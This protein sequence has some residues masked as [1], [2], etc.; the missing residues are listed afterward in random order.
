MPSP[1]AYAFVA[2]RAG[3]RCEYCLAPEALFNSPFDVDHVVPI[4]HGGGRSADNL[5]L[6]LPSRLAA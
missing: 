3:H 4:A 5:A 1:S 2:E 6:A